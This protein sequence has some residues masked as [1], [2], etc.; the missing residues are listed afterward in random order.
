MSSSNRCAVCASQRWQF[1][2]AGFVDDA[3]VSTW[4]PFGRDV[5]SEYGDA[6]IAAMLAA[7]TLC[8]CKACNPRRLAPWAKSWKTEGDNA[9]NAQQGNHD[10]TPI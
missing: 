9:A 2:R 10:A 3:L 7:K 4:R 8:P 5:W 1:A 6:A